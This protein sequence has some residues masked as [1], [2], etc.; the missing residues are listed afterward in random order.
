VQFILS[1]WKQLTTRSFNGQIF[2]AA[3]TVALMTVIV[4]VASVGKELVVAWRFGTGDDLDA[5]FIAWLIPSL[6]IVVLAD[7]FNGALLPIFIRVREQESLQSA[8]KLL[9]SVVVLSIA[10]LGITAIL[11]VWTAPIY[12]PLIAQGFSLEKL[13]LTK[14][15]LLV[16]APIVPISG[17]AVIWGTVLNAGERFAGAALAPISTPL[18]SIFFLLICKQLKIFAL[19]LGFVCG[20]IIEVIFLGISLKKQGFSLLPKWYG[21]ERHLRYCAKQYLPTLAGAFLMFSTTIVDQSM[22]AVLSPG[23]VAALNYGTKFVTL[24]INLT[25]TALSVA[26]IPYFSKMVAD[27]NW[28]ELRHTLKFY[29]ILSFVVTVP[30]TIFFMLFSQPL[31]EFLLQKGAFSSTDSQ[32]VGQIQVLYALQ[33]PFYVAATVVV[34]ALVSM[35]LNHILIWAAGLNLLINIQLNYSFLQ[36]LGVKGIALSTSC[37]HAC[38]FVF[39]FLCLKYNLPKVE[40]GLK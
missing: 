37:V 10:I 11:M 32:L 30:L 3:L 18:I 7:S 21:F 1:K 24:P 14:Q 9:S 15:L 13:A 26:V 20:S 5:F 4:K 31:V 16:I 19:P 35:G 36:W 34:R 25:A 27:R 33:I 6:L 29:L 17:I 28:F 39:V 2:S 22:A 40:N 12:L 38:S 23:S 8:Q